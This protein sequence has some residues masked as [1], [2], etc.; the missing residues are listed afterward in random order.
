MTYK[1][2]YNVL[3]VGIVVMVATV[4]IASNT[5]IGS[6]NQIGHASVAI[7]APSKNMQSADSSPEDWGGWPTVAIIKGPYPYSNNSEDEC[8]P[9]MVNRAKFAKAAFS[10]MYGGYYWNIDEYRWPDSA[11]FET[12][13]ENPD[14]GAIYIEHNGEDPYMMATGI[15]YPPFTC[16]VV[17][18]NEIYNYMYYIGQPMPLTF[19]SGPRSLCHIQ[20]GT[21]A[22]AF[23]LDD[24][25]SGT[26]VGYCLDYC[27]DCVI[28]PYF[29]IGDD[30]VTVSDWEQV[31]FYELSNHKTIEDAMYSANSMYPECSQCAIVLGNDQDTLMLKY[32]DGTTSTDD[33]ECGEQLESGNTYSLPA[34]LECSGMYGLVAEGVHDVIID[35]VGHTL[36]AAAASVWIADS[37]DIT[38]KNCNIETSGITVID[39]SSG[40]TLED[41]EFTGTYIGVTILETSEDVL[42]RDNTFTNNQVAI[43]IF[44]DGVE[45]IDNNACTNAI[46]VQCS[47]EQDTAGSNNY[48]QTVEDCGYVGYAPCESGGVSGGSSPIMAKQGSTQD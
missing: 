31:F 13:L 19:L 17:S 18:A 41:N 34:D 12:I 23:A 33:P 1:L 28:E 44:E 6:E 36:S 16:E 25:S 9:C 22:G 24:F 42:L 32:R 20:P 46:D 3:M 35:C 15:Q 45:L 39:G 48:F 37:Q 38:V 7:G 29:E 30:Q 27:P 47:E 8:G 21:L 26:V 4:A 11:D 40:V 10:E 2:S 43:D 5:N 14:V